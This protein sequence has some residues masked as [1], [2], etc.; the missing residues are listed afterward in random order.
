MVMA[1]RWRR[2]ATLAV[3]FVVAIM[4]PGSTNQLGAVLP[5]RDLE[6]RLGVLSKRGG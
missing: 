1:D 4:V 3:V 2:V 5:V 6:E